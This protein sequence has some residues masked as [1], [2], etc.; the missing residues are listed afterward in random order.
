M[1]RLIRA[2][3][4]TSFETKT[5]DVAAENTI[6]VTMY[7][8]PIIY[9][10]SE[11]ILGSVMKD[12][13]RF[14]T[15]VNPAREINGP[16]SEYG[17][18]LEPPIREEYNAFI[19]DCVWLVKE[20]GFTII[21]RST[22]TDS[23]KSEYL[24]LFGIDDTPYGSIVFDLRISDHPF[25]ATFPEELKD[26]ALDYLKINKVLDESATQAGINFQI[27]KVTVGSVKH[28]SWNK[29]FNRL[30]DKLKQMRNKIQKA[31]RIREMQNKK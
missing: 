17:E 4:S 18:M 24:I 8:H 5:N 3:Q 28:D 7:L 10:D 16:L 29:A 13:H 12:G 27:E 30:F 6:Y 21:N 11:I 22:S 14:S 20:F 1:K 19:E 31:L 26:K 2:K 9:S 25:D 15:D 23:K